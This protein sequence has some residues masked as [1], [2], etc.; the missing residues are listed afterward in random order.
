[1]ML[2]SL[3]NRQSWKGFPTEG[4]LR[5]ERLH[6]ISTQPARILEADLGANLPQLSFESAEA[7]SIVCLYIEF[8][9]D[10]R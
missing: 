4:Q 8:K 2:V 9:F 10:E 5:R 7:S 3:R 6:E 1:M